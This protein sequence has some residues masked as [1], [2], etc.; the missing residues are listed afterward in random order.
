[1]QLGAEILENAHNFKKGTRVLGLRGVISPWPGSVMATHKGVLQL[2][3][4]GV[5]MLWWG[6]GSIPHQE[7]CITE[8]IL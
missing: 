2:T 1:M 3:S 5:G 6:V 4:M 8:V 7:W